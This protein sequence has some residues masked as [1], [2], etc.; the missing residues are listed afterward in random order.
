MLYLYTFIGILRGF[1]AGS[2]VMNSPA[3]A[4]DAGDMGLILGSERSS[5]GGNGNP[6]QCFCL[7]NP[8]DRRAWQ[9]RV[10]RVTRVRH[11]LVTKPPPSYMWQ[12]KPTYMGENKERYCDYKYKI[13]IIFS[14]VG[15]G[16]ESSQE[17]RH[18]WDF[19]LTITFYF[20]GWGLCIFVLYILLL[21]IY[22]GKSTLY[23]ISIC[24]QT[25]KFQ[26]N[27]R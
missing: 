25:N 20:L 19:Q 12:W 16:K 2:V 14:P 27:F 3:R 18:R 15:L 22:T 11:N 6:L 24:N 4:G 9:A 23:L 8:M 10:H 26:K 7:E 5:G 13:W 1:L 21:L 17:G